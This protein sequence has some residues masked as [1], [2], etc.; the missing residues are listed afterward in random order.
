ML[1]L[2]F[3]SGFKLSFIEIKIPIKVKSI[4]IPINSVVYGPSSFE[5][6]RKI[7]DQIGNEIAWYIILYSFCLYNLIVN[8]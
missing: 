6:K 8:I 2:F 3:E 4:K 7:I 1:L 5:M